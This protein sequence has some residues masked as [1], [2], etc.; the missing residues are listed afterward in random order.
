MKYIMALGWGVIAGVAVG[1][2]LAVVLGILNIYLAGHGIHWPSETFE[3]RFI[4]LSFL[5]AVLLSGCL[6]A[7]LLVSGLAL[8]GV[9]WRPSDKQGQR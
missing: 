5:D 6:M 8:W 2:A 4:S 9:G 3:W 1:F 7:F